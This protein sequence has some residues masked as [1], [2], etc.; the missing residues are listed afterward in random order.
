MNTPHVSYKSGIF[1]DLTWPGIAEVL[2]KYAVQLGVNILSWN[3][4]VGV[5]EPDRADNSLTVVFTA[6]PNGY[7]RRRVEMASA[8]GITL[9]ERQ[10]Q[11]LSPTEDLEHQI[12]DGEGNIVAEVW[13]ST[14]YVLFN[15]PKGDNAAALMEYI[16]QD[17]ARWFGSTP[18]ER[19]EKRAEVIRV[20]KETTVQ[21]FKDLVSS[22]L[23]FSPGYYSAKEEELKERERE[24]SEEILASQVERKNLRRLKGLS[25]KIEKN[26]ADPSLNRM[27]KEIKA[28]AVNDGFYVTPNGQIHVG[29]GQID[30]KYRGNVYDIG[31]FEIVIW[32]KHSR[33]NLINTTRIVEEHCHPHVDGHGNPCFGN[34]DEQVKVFC[35]GMQYVM[36]IR[37]L[38]V[39]LKT[40]HRKEWYVSVTE[41]PMKKREE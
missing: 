6:V 41:W 27:L 37:L 31:E 7:D 28:Y 39:F 35:N 38:K 13:D 20:F 1:G 5:V 12:S 34:I 9:D 10:R 19:A 14:L 33:V 24:L 3:E 36:L 4:N 17:Y 11:A 25:R 16:M 40:C 2:E 8:Y 22:T 21:A 15:L 29:I 26:E 30:I 23:H 32:P 18:E